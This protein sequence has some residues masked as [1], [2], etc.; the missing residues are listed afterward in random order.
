MLLGG[1]LIIRQVEQHEDRL[2]EE[3]TAES[4]SHLSS[5]LRAEAAAMA[6]SVDGDLHEALTV[7]YGTQQ[8]KDWSS[9]PDEVRAYRRELK[10]KASQLSLDATVTTYRIKSAERMNVE[11]R[12]N[13]IRP[14]ALQEFF[15]SD[16]TRTAWGAD[17]PYLPDME[18][19]LV[20][21]QPV[22]IMLE[23]EASSQI[24]AFAAIES[25][26]GDLVGFV[27]L[28]TPAPTVAS[29]ASQRTSALIPAMGGAGMILLL[30]L[31]GVTAPLGRD[32]RKL[33]D[34]IATLGRREDS[35]PTSS[36]L[37]DLSDVLDQAQQTEKNISRLLQREAT[38]R[39]DLE[40]RLRD[41]ELGLCPSRK[42]YRDRFAKAADQIQATISV[43]S[44]HS[45]P[46]TL[47]DLTLE[48]AIF[49]LPSGGVV[50]LAPGFPARIR[51]TSPDDDQVAEFVVETLKSATVGK[52]SLL[53]LR[54]TNPSNLR[55]LPRELRYLV[56]NRCMVCV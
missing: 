8:L 3:R 32:L 15:T 16:D 45:V 12:S 37:R 17:T 35:E 5:Q 7:G 33:T 48:E 24:T 36:T 56:D 20:P 40:A 22:A 39:T 50:D 27:R 34:R 51:I 54:I 19:P 13:E 26:Q 52:M 18:L 11:A 21:H 29:M 53:R 23:D 31:F 42:S 43:D 44:N 10:S 9:A 46:G 4:R 41:A 1:T 2:A 6:A 55:A 28:D 38:A 14:D 25:Y 30:V 49:G 47:V